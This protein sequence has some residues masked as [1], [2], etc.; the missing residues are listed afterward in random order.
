VRLG[1]R[2]THGRDETQEEGFTLIELTVALSLLAVVMMGFA[3]AVYGSMSAWAASRQRSAFVEIANGE[4][5]T[6][7]ALPYSVVG[8][9]TTAD[10][11]WAAAYDE[12]GKRDGRDHVDVTA[13]DTTSK[14]PK[15]VST[16]TTSQVK[17]ITLP[18]TVRR[19]V[20][21]TDVTGGSSHIFKRLELTV[22]W[23]E[24]GR[25]ARSLTLT[26][27]LYPGGLGATTTNTDPVASFTVSPGQSVNALQTATFDG[28]AS[29]DADG[30]AMTYGWNFGDGTTISGGPSS[31]THAYTLAGTYT[32]VLTVTDARG[33]VGSTSKVM[34]VAALV[35]SPPTASFSRTP[36]N[37][38]APLAVN[39]DATASSDPDG[40]ALTYAWSWGDATA[41]G[42]GVNATHTFASAGTFTITLTV[43]DTSNATSTATS[44][45]TVTP[46]NCDVTSGS[47]KNPSTNGSSND[48][49]VGSNNKPNNNSFTFYATSNA[50]CTTV[51]A[52]LPYQ[53]GT[54]AVA[55]SQTG[56]SNGVV[57][58]SAASS[59]DSND[60]FNTGTAQTG[61]FW[62]P[63]AD[64]TADKY[65]FSFNVH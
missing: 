38:I 9:N 29:A 4:M 24:N 59:F 58:W 55:L 21:W 26:S 62:S 65:S 37:G 23:T 19:W 35:N 64:G 30:D 53:G 15:T 46:L 45:V 10:P 3:G 44:T 5:E 63:G 22:S 13:A 57:S 27:V 39:V 16:V 54:W 6:L 28:A 14:A 33:G 32:A 52:R 18:Y 36:S 49:A 42:S 2:G 17:G 48:I 40:N 34:T 51:S 25:A 8:V 1:T 60:K 7:R 41:N 50:A 43:S 56:T 11:S 31:T 47:F 20:T 12:T 61:E